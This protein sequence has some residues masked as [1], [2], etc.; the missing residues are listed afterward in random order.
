MRRRSV[1]AGFAAAFASGQ[2]IETGPQVVS[3]F[4]EIDNSN[5]PYALYVPRSYT[6]ARSW[7]VVIGL[8]GESSSYRVNLLQIFGRG[9]QFSESDMLSRRRFPVLADVDFLVACPMARGDMGF[10]G[11]PGTDVLDVLADLKRRFTVDEDRVYLTGIGMGG[12]GALWLGMTRPDIWA[13]VAAVCPEPPAGLEILAGNAANVP[14]ALYQGAID[15]LVPA[16]QT[17]DWSQ[18]L[19]DAGVAVDYVEYPNVRHNAWD[20]AYRDRAI[21]NWFG[22]YRRVIKPKRVRFVSDAYSRSSA[23]WL[24]FDQLTPGVPASATAELLDGALRIETKN[25]DGFSVDSTRLPTRPSTVIIDGSAV[26]LRPNV[27]RF[28]RR[29]KGWIPGIVGPRFVDDRKR[30]GA[31][32]PVAAAINARHIYIYGSRD[33][34]APA[35][36]IRR[37]DVARQAAEWSTPQRPL[38]VHFKAM[39]DTEATDPQTVG[40]NFVL[41]GNRITNKRVAALSD[42]LPIHLSPS[43]ADYG[44]VYVYPADNRYVVVSSGLPWWTRLDQAK[45]PGLPVS[46]PPWRVLENLGDFILFRGGIDNVIVE[47]R[48]DNEWRLP[49]DAKVKMLST[50]AVEISELQ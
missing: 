2:T 1:L 5:Q 47:G 3:Y 38:Q 32:G 12:G 26:R 8:H 50:G 21:F 16:V 43:A 39:S 7:P 10:Q 18:R 19:K 20:F 11:I 28:V 34:P 27:W 25:L 4:S 17:R 40:A 41:F 33:N 46:S 45:R 14:T 22:Q 36:L 30:Q 48:F 49:S 42:K 15:P 13:A 44:L 31:E 9:L 35:E 37:R 23:Y 24:L 29:E 6:P